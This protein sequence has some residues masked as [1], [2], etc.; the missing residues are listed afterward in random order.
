MKIFV[1]I[2][3]YFLLISG[4]ILLIF[5]V[6]WFPDFYDVRY[7]GVASFACA[8]VIFFLPKLMRVKNNVPDHE[9]KNYATDLFQLGITIAVINNA[10]GDLGLYQLY[11]VG[12]EY[13]KLIH[14]STSFII[15]IFLSL[16][17]RNRFQI[18]AYY[19]IVVAFLIVVGSGFLWEVFEFV[20]DN[21]LRTHIFGLY[22]AD[23]IN[24][25]KWDLIYNL[26]GFSSAI[27]IMFFRQHRKNKRLKNQ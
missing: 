5:P 18:R 15:T 16:L 1:K 11:K 17:L 9:K 24:D 14:F 22:G 6:H 4:V 21:L 12:F 20:S 13:D 25:T 2:S 19:S 10:L 8:A 3:L 7:M 26:I 27:I 23:Q